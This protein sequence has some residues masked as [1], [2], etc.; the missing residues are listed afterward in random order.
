MLF[1]DHVVAVQKKPPSGE[2]NFFLFS[3]ESTE[4]FRNFAG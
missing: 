3:F 4:V 2:W 1:T